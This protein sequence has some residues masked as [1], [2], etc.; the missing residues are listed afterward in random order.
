MRLNLEPYL[1]KKKKVSEIEKQFIRNDDNEIIKKIRPINSNSI[2][3]IPSNNL[4]NFIDDLNQKANKILNSSIINNKFEERI[5]KK[6][7]IK[8]NK[9][10]QNSKNS[11]NFL[12]PSN[13]LYIK[14]EKALM[15]KSIK[16]NISDYKNE[17]KQKFI[18][19]KEKNKKFRKRY[20]S[21][22][23]IQF[24]NYYKPMNEQR[25]NDFS[26]I[27]KKCM[28]DIII[29]K[30]NFKLPQIK[31]NI[32][33]VYS[34]LYHNE[35]F[36]KKIKQKNM[37]L[38]PKKNDNK[39]KNKNNNL[40]KSFDENEN[41]NIYYNFRNFQV[42]NIIQNSNG[43]EF[44]I[45]ITPEIKKKCLFNYSG[46]PKKNIINDNINNNIRNIK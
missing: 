19:L 4:S 9:E 43:K 22:S 38:N 8:L 28:S 11:K 16:R 10:K 36:L 27:L 37:N 13:S 25:V 14:R 18:N 20:K 23:Q 29:R 5:F 15:L 30:E 35:V 6:Q 46:D 17:R 41:K 39:I 34:R 7:K 2:S 45:K 1:D 26:R 44:T 33:D 31:L 24:E 21:C 32:N 12:N 42:K 3:K 40:N